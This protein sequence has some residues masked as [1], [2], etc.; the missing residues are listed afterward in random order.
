V[1]ELLINEDKAYYSYDSTIELITQREEQRDNGI[2]S[3]RYD[4]E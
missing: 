1:F 3:F 4:S 2:F